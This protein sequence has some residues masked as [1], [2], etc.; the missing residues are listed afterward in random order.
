MALTAL[1]SYI[2]GT[3]PAHYWPL[4]E[5]SGAAIDAVAGLNSSSLNCTQNSA[6]GASDGSVNY[7]FTTSQ[8]VKFTTQALPTSGPFSIG[9]GTFIFSQNFTQKFVCSSG[10]Q[11]QAITR[12]TNTGYGMSTAYT[13]TGFSYSGWHYIILTFNG[14]TVAYYMDGVK[15][16]TIGTGPVGYVTS[17]TGFGFGNADSSGFGVQGDIGKVAF[18]TSVLPGA[19]A[20]AVATAYLTGVLPTP[21]HRRLQLGMGYGF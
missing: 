6:S 17:D 12:S 8:Y 5:T 9:F 15:D 11:C 4:S 19:T 21:G 3:G 2:I 10:S 1:D 18:W 13:T 14:T 7:A 20:L 16:T